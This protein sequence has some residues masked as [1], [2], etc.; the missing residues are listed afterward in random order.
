MKA[1]VTGANG[2]LGVHLVRE[3][4]A[5]GHHVRAG[6]RH[7]EDPARR[8]RFAACAGVELA[9]VDLDRPQEFAAALEGID[10]LF[11]AAAVYRLC[12][13][14][15]DAEIERASTVGLEALLRAASAARVRKVV[16]TSSLLCVPLTRRSAPAS[17][18]AQW[19]E[20]LQ[21][22]Y[23]RAK[24]QGER[25]A[26]KL[27]DELRLN[28]VALLPGSF[29]GPGF[30]ANTPT[31]DV[32]ECM[33][34]GGF[35]AG[36]PQANL[37]YVDVRDVARAHRMAAQQDAQGRFIIVN[38][39]QPTFRRLVEVMHDI[40]ARIRLPRSTLPDFMMPLAPVF[41]LLNAATLGT[42]RTISAKW[43]ASI[44]GKSFNASNRKAREVLGWAPAVSLSQS[45]ADT[46]AELL[47]RAKK[48]ANAP[49]TVPAAPASHC[50]HS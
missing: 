41:D 11:H 14:A 26:W 44:R 9:Q 22:P 19:N 49:P 2:H 6:V 27:A 48:P 18:E 1:L 12:D 15:R 33:M 23:T 25:L 20:D 32:L 50:T 38:D 30:A 45:V 21:V 28:L 36:V 34:R 16:L 5:N 29:G 40:D 4:L 13:S 10:V 47:S 3:L 17:T 39:E 43:A 46:M 42:P 8:A 7:P 24:T 37:P 35:R 31:I